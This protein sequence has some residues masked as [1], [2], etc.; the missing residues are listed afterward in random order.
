M[1]NLMIYLLLGIGL[2]GITVQAEEAS[3]PEFAAIFQLSTSDQASVAAA[4]TK[5]AASDCRKGMPTG[6]RIMR[7]TFNG[8]ED[9]SHLSLIHI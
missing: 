7:E 2:S 3:V 1:K 9:I 6:I 5:F 4:F 8:T